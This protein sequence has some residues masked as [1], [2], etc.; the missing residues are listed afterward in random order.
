MRDA[1]LIRAAALAHVSWMSAVARVTGGGASADAGVTLIGRP[2]ELVLA[3]P[4][5]PADAVEDALGRVRASGRRVVGCWS[6][7]LDPEADAALGDTL[8]GAGLGEGWQPHWMAARIDAIADPG[9]PPDPRVAPATEVPEYDGYGQ[10]LLLMTRESPPRSR[11]FVAREEG[12]LAG[13]AWTHV[14]PAAPDVAGVFDV[15]VMDDRRRRGIG[16][17]LTRVAAADAARHGAAHVVLNATGD[18]ERLYAALGF[19]SLGFGRTWWLP[20]PG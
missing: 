4:S 13:L 16:S 17:A 11:H 20:R 1:D 5:A 14:A 12:E 2:D 18:G 6:T 3:F 9:A 15:H 8:A 19:R 7:G 10:A